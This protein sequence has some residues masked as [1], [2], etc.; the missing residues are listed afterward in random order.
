MSTLFHVRDSL[1][2]AKAL[3]LWRAKQNRIIVQKVWM[4]NRQQTWSFSKVQVNEHS[5][6]T[7]SRIKWF[8]MPTGIGFALIAFIQLRHV[9][10]REN[11]K[12]ADPDND[13]IE[14]A[15]PLRL[16]TLFKV[17]PT[18]VL[19]R[20]WGKVNDIDLPVS[21][22]GPAIRFWTWAFDCCL[23]EAEEEDMSKYPNLG[24]FFTRKLKA[25]ARVIDQENELV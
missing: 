15:I 5:T 2:F 4:F 23:E 20:L 12:D 7:S 11:R 21:L 14:K 24:A 10:E 8:W 13:V 1:Q 17:V 22:R 19:S 6:K 25:D 9:R 18:R 3:S 16:V